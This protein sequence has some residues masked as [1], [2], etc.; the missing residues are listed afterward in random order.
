MLSDHLV[1]CTFSF[2]CI[3]N[4]TS[5]NQYWCVL[6]MAE[7]LKEFSRKLMN[8]DAF[9]PEIQGWIEQKLQL[10]LSGET[11]FHSPFQVDQLRLLDYSLV[12]MSLQQLLRMPVSQTC[13]SLP[14][15]AVCLAVEDFM[16]TAT[17]RLWETFWDASEEPAPTPF[18]ILGP[19]TSASES[20]SVSSL[21]RE[22]PL[23]GAAIVAR[24]GSSGKGGRVL[25]DH[26]AAYVEVR[27]D[28]T[29]ANSKSLMSATS[30]EVIGRALFHGLLMLTSR[31]LAKKPSVHYNADTAYILLVNSRNGGVV[32]LKGDVSKLETN[33]DKVY[34]RAAEWI[35]EQAQVTVCP[36]EQVWNRFGNANWGDIGA[37]QLLL[38]IFHSI[39]QCRGPPRNP[40]A[41]MAALHNGRVQRRLMKRES[42][43]MQEPGETGSSQLSNSLQRSSR[44]GILEIEEEVKGKDSRLASEHIM[45]LEP[46]TIFWLES[47]HWQRGFQIQGLLGRRNSSVYS[48]ISLDEVGK[49]LAVHVGAHGPEADASVEYNATERYFQQILGPDYCLRQT[50]AP[51][52]LLKEEFNESL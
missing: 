40:L 36:L 41:E 24:N 18:Y 2:Y 45:K 28:I 14:E 29:G 7:G 37:M 12:S 16:H 39:E 30:L 1:G 47:A 15:P 27:A 48:A 51:R 50:D 22:A 3:S 31:S 5:N 17:Q 19:Q 8:V 32:R 20:I 43:E 34:E 46:G 6:T 9:I 35:K 21:E 11:G 42:L 38:A 44:R 10:S 13:A 33:T 25:W 52:A 23:P 49:P 26:V 4:L